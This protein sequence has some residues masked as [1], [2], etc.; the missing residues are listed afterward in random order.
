VVEALDSV[1]KWIEKLQAAPPATP[2]PEEAPASPTP[3]VEALSP[4]RGPRQGAKRRQAQVLA[5][6]NAV[7]A[8]ILGEIEAIQTVEPVLGRRESVKRSKK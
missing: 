1:A 6:D 7:E 3:E 5:S 4:Q 2:A 8:Q